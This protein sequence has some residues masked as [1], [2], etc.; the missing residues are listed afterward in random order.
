MKILSSM[1]NPQ[2]ELA[3]LVEKV[4]EAEFFLDSGIVGTLNFIAIKAAESPPFVEAWEVENAEDEKT[5][6]HVQAFGSR[7]RG[8]MVISNMPTHDSVLLFGSGKKFDGSALF[9]QK[10]DDIYTVVYHRDKDGKKDCF[11][12]TSTRDKYLVQ[13]ILFLMEDA[14]QD[15]DVHA[16]EDALNLLVASEEEDRE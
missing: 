13:I 9:V 4:K 5:H 1:K 6:I 16:V 2:Q 8:E 11:R 7:H 15:A 12:L 3:K 14:F 10:F